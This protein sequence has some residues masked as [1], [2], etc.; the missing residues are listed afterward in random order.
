MKTEPTVS[1]FGLKA[2]TIEKI[3]TVLRQYPEID[4]AVLY[5]S[6]AKGNYR[7]G[8]DIDLML[9][10][11]EMTHQHLTRLARQLDDLLLPYF[12]DL[13]I[14]HRIEDPDLIDHIKRI[15]VVFYERPPLAE[16]KA[17]H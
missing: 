15:G 5:G 2:S 12:F 16:L 3:T 11:E 13:S 6:R 8:S 1:K 7:T 4:R 17:A 9:I 10:G 14:F